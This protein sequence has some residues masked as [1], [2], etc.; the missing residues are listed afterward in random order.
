M[1]IQQA[2]SSEFDTDAMAECL[3]E[4]ELVLQRHKLTVGEL[5]LVCG[6]LLYKLG[7]NVRRNVYE[8]NFIAEPPPLDAINKLY[9]QNPTVDLA[10]MLTGLTISTW[11]DDLK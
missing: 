6:N 3:S 5:L 11:L 10:L 2:D 7:A 1:K 9:Y 4:L 8:E